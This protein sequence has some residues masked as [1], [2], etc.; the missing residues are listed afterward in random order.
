MIRRRKEIYYW[1]KQHEVNFIIKEPDNKL[2]AINVS[3]T[4]DIP[5]R[6]IE[7]LVEFMNAYNDQDVELLILAEDLEEERESIQISPVWKWL[8]R[9]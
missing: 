7:G 5:E 3:Y 2:R 8:L 1:K 6:E 9:G 4:N